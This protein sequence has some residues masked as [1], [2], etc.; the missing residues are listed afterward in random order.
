MVDNRVRKNM[1]SLLRSFLRPAGRTSSPLQAVAGRR[2]TKPRFQGLATLTG[3][4]LIPTLL[5]AQSLAIDWFKVSG[6]GGTSS[7][8]QYRVRGTIGQHEASGPMVG[9]TFSIT[10]GFWALSAVQTPG[11]P[12]LTITCSGNQAIVSWPNSFNGW[13]LQTNSDLS[14]AH[15][16]NYQGAILN[17]A[18]AISPPMGNVFFRLVH[19]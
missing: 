15:W 19:P 13:M 7:N 10:G 2:A 17:N 16:G 1:S 6:G 9:S 5:Q 18:A 12:L 14:T 3:L 8:G 4:L 11:A